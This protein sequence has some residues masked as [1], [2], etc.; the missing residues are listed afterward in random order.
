MV[1]AC[2]SS[3]AALL[4]LFFYCVL[5]LH[6]HLFHETNNEMENP[7]RYTSSLFYK[8]AAQATPITTDPDQHLTPNDDGPNSSSDAATSAIPPSGLDEGSFVMHDSIQT[9]FFIGAGLG[10]TGTTAVY[11]AMCLLGFPSV[12]FR[13]SCIHPPMM[14]NGS[15]HTMAF[16]RVNDSVNVFHFARG[17]SGKSMNQLQMEAAEKML[18][19]EE[20]LSAHTRLLK[21]WRSLRVCARRSRQ[22]RE[23]I[24]SNFSSS[25]LRGGCSNFTGI[26][27]NLNQHASQVVASG[28]A[29]VTDT[30][31]PFLINFLSQVALKHRPNTVIILTERDPEAWVKSRLRHHNGESDLMC[32]ETTA[33]AAAFD[34]Q[35]CLKRNENLQQLSTE[36][37][38]TT[39]SKR[40]YHVQNLAFQHSE[41]IGD[42]NNY[43]SAAE[44]DYYRSFLAKAVKQ[45]HARIKTNKNMTALN[46]PTIVINLW[47]EDFPT[48]P[49]L[50]QALWKRMKPILPPEILLQYENAT[51]LQSLRR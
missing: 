41:I 30:P 36:S 9:P 7:R 10:T 3:S 26:V 14:S 5:F 25:R 51:P 20:G 21:S 37:S 50:A 48:V 29:F 4:S 40:H 12:H 23:D 39:M 38:D 32:F 24:L 27:D 33:I 47:A 42:K 28:L 35:E 13:R 15:G 18:L 1:K 8:D 19:V 22:Q 17:R 16:N 46:W 49:D 2:H 31:Y 11:N 44:K 6:F 34:L 45:H 43:Y